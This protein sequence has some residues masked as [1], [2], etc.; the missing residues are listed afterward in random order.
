ML[1]FSTFVVLVPFVV[2]LSCVYLSSLLL[3]FVG[4]SLVCPSP[5]VALVC[6]RRLGSR[7]LFFCRRTTHFPS[8]SQVSSPS[9]TSVM[10]YRKANLLGFGHLFVHCCPQC[11]F[12]TSLP[13]AQTYCMLAA[14]AG[15]T[16]RSPAMSTAMKFRFNSLQT[17]RRLCHPAHGSTTVLFFVLLCG[18]IRISLSHAAG[19]S[20]FFLVA[21]S[22]LKPSFGFLA[23]LSTQR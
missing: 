9:G 15:L 6:F 23:I 3:A 21:P 11:W 7:S 2:C 17:G 14:I 19:I 22:P 8:G 12:C 10:T 18:F 5:F 4:L 16:F 1:N 20:F 13:S